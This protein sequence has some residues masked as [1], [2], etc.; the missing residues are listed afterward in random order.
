M[1]DQPMSALFGRDRASRT[2]RSP[3]WWWVPQRD[4]R[5]IREGYRAF[6]AVGNSP[7]DARIKV[8]L[9]AGTRVVS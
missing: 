4:V 6:R 8:M 5:W 1:Q 2:P 3:V 9:V 7:Q